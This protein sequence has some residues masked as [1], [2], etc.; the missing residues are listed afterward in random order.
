MIGEA[1]WSQFGK[2][3]SEK[4]PQKYG[5]LADLETA[6]F[7]TTA[8]LFIPPASTTQGHHRL[9]Y[10]LRGARN[11]AVVKI[12]DQPV[13]IPLVQV[14]NPLVLDFLNKHRPIPVSVSAQT[15]RASNDG[16]TLKHVIICGRH[17]IRASTKKP[18]QLAK[19]AVG[20]YPD[21]GVDPGLLTRNGWKAELL[22][23]S[24]FHDYLVHERLL[25]G[26]TQEDLARSY[27]RAQAIERT[28]LTAAAFQTAVIPGV[29]QPQIHSYP[30]SPYPIDPL[31]DPIFNQVVAVDTARAVAE[32][33]G[34]FNNGAALASAYSG[35]LSLVRSVLFDYPIDTQPLP[36]TPEEKTDATSE[37]IPLTANTQLYVGNVIQVGGLADML[38]A[39]DPFIMQYADGFPLDQVAW[40]SLSLDALS[41]QTRLTNLCFRIEMLS[42]YLNQ[43]QSSNFAAHVLRT[44]E[45]AVKGKNTLGAFGTARS[46]M[47]VIISS[48]AYLAGLAG[49]LNLHWQ[50]P[51]YQAD[52]CS[53]GGALVLELRQSNKTKGYFVRAF[54]TAQTLDQLRNLTPLTLE[55]PPSTM[56]LLIPGGSQSATDLGVK[57]KTFQKLVEKAIDPKYVQHPF[58]EFQ[59]PVLLLDNPFLE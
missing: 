46:R 41:Q 29:T 35:E 22:L 55:N 20:T 15:I 37:A 58:T 6:L 23:G 13:P 5:R 3:A 4:Y 8:A 53:P 57:F 34:I 25:T 9:E 45:Q 52:F 44:L 26:N 42:P 10:S 36:P 49:L 24:Y 12:N 54:F 38:D 59:P 50:L 11:I 14:R 27:F 51:G 2:A 18:A 19:F 30:I 1:P 48:D 7:D 47:T 56:P 39:T 28:N 32:T 33:R 40:G 17:S 31:F 43:L 16:T 21:F